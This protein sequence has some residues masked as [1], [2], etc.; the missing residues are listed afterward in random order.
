MRGFVQIVI[1]TFLETSFHM[2]IMLPC[3]SQL[4]FALVCK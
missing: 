3:F 4:H 1:A 2:L